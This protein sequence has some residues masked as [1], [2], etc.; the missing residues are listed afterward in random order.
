M[1]NLKAAFIFLVIIG[2]GGCDQNSYEQKVQSLPA[3]KTDILSV[4]IK[5]QKVSGKVRNTKFSLDQAVLLGGTL[6]LKQGTEFFADVGVDIITFSSEDLDGKKFDSSQPIQSIKPHIRLIVKKEGE[7]LPEFLSIVTDYEL[8]L[9]FSE[10][11]DFGIP[12]A[13][14]LVS[15]KN[16][17]Y[18]EGRSIATDKDI[19]LVDGDIDT[20]FD[21]FD[22]I[23]YLAKSYISEHHVG[24]EVGHR[25]GI[26]TSGFAKDYP[27][28][29][30]VGYEL[31][32]SS[33][34]HSIVKLQLSKDENGWKV[35]KELGANQIHQAHPVITITDQSLRTVE[36]AKA[37][38]VA[39]HRLETFLNQ[40]GMIENVR[41][42]RV[43]CTLTDAADKASCR[44]IYALKDQ[45][46]VACQTRNYLLGNDENGWEFETE[47][48][49]TQQVDYKSGQLVTYKPSSASCL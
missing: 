25:F 6:Q 27:K 24:V 39:G 48:L 29:G 17:T 34:A 16:Q 44:A 43:R 22:T 40:Q 35:V 37:T 21:S 2:F 15:L 10:K 31:T 46:Q 18:I 38:A 19:M 45:D 36:G 30:F 3:S 4:P 20:S 8:L 9:E 13:I 28:S 47:I 32:T 41:A 1:K 23:E 5:D 42:T 49:D 12:F 26:T 7:N 11:N 14:R 33:G